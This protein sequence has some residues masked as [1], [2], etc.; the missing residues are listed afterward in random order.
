MGNVP[1]LIGANNYQQ[2]RR[3]S[4]EWV[5]RCESVSESV[6]SNRYFSGWFSWQFHTFSMRIWCR[7]MILSRSASLCGHGLKFTFNQRF[8]TT[9]KMNN[10]RYAFGNWFSTKSYAMSG[11][12]RFQPS[13]YLLAYYFNHERFFLYDRKY[14]SRS[15]AK[16][17]P[18]N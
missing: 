14:S 1:C 9:T 6:M 11:I 3:V 5:D 13:V 2:R 8:E 7:K 4:L 17:Y 16:T 12:Y 15:I 10:K 18:A